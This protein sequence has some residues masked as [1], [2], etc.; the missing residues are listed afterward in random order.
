M[1]PPPLN[2]TASLLRITQFRI[3]G[4]AFILQL[5]P[6]AMSTATLCSMIEFRIV[7]LLL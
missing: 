2:T 6:P 4:L 1:I 5:I 3:V 7:G